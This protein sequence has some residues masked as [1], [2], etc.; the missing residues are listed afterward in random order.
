MNHPLAAANTL[1]LPVQANAVTAAR[2]TV[3]GGYDPY[4]GSLPAPEITV[5]AHAA[6]WVAPTEAI[7]V[8]AAGCAGCLF[9]GDLGHLSARLTALI[10]REATH[11]V[12]APWRGSFDAVEVLL[13]RIDG[14]WLM[15][16]L[17]S[18]DSLSR[19]AVVPSL[20]A[21]LEGAVAELGR[22]A[23]KGKRR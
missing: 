22:R 11:R 4:A 9:V 6:V 3:Q 23:T 17:G 18:S 7:G 1:N 12:V 13:A 5:R 20:H 14:G 8:F 15:R 2:L 21:A 19:I 16:T 10:E